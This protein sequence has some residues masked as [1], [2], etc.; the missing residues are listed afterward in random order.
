MKKTD[1]DWYSLVEAEKVFD[2]NHMD[3]LKL[4]ATGKI[5]LYALLDKPMSKVNFLNRKPEGK[6]YEYL[7]TPCFVGIS[8]SDILRLYVNPDNQHETNTVMTSSGEWGLTNFDEPIRFYWFELF[9]MAD[10]LKA[11]FQEERVH[12][13]N[14]LAKILDSNH[15]WHSENLAMAVNAWLELYANR[16][17]NRNDSTFKPPGGNTKLINDWLKEKN[18]SI[19]TT[20]QEHFR[21]IINPDKR[22]GPNK[23]SE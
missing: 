10:H 9:I 5:K 20:T 7:I 3:F 15:P 21:V 1:H 19:G 6:K 17:G 23:L 2:Y 12:N 8:E 18:Q 4:G 16:E 14:Q 13:E 11:I 22:G